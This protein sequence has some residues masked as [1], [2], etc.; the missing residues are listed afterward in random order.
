MHDGRVDLLHTR[1][2]LPTVNNWNSLRYP[3][4]L[5]NRQG[6]IEIQTSQNDVCLVSINS[7]MKPQSLLLARA[8]IYFALDAARVGAWVSIQST[9]CTWL[10]PLATSIVFDFTKTL[11]SLS[12]FW[13][14]SHRKL[15]YDTNVIRYD[16]YE[17]KCIVIIMSFELCLLH[18]IPQLPCC[19][20][21]LVGTLAHLSI[22][23]DFYSG[24]LSGNRENASK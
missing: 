6:F 22:K 20:S 8:P 5:R 9:V 16:P 13:A 10:N 24:V 12:T 21:H 17:V 11:P 14:N 7:H 1:H 3:C 4:R 2:H 15:T 23:H 18:T 19:L